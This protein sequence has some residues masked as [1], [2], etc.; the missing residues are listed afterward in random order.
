[1]KS[2]LTYRA[3]LCDDSDTY[4]AVVKLAL[5]RDEALDLV[6]EATNGLEAIKAVQELSPDLLLLD[7]SMPLMTGLEALP[8]I[9]KRFPD[10]IVFMNTTQTS[11]AL[12]DRA[13]QLG[14]AAWLDKGDGLRG[15]H[16]ALAALVT[17]P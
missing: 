16:E 9:R 3:V 10:V 17:H 4:R 2:K 14:A 7:V 11:G 13:M 8:E 5:G 1:M 6:G 12:R 15:I